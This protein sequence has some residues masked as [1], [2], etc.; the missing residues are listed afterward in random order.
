VS[1]VKKTV[2]LPKGL[3]VGGR[4]LWRDVTRQHVLRPDSLRILAD[5]CFECDLIDD[6]QS[7]LKDA[8]KTTRGSMGQEVIHPLI[9]ELR[10]HRA[11]LSTLLR[12]LALA[13]SDTS[14]VDASRAATQSAIGLAR[15]RWDRKSA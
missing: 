15:A 11:T 2:T 6:L 5:A 9:S 10:Q 14:A 8:P 12:G 4:A 1:P 7:A 13:D 3:G